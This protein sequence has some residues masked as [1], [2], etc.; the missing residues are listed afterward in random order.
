MENIVMTFNWNP[1]SRPPPSG[2]I[3]DNIRL[4]P[5]LNKI[6]PLILLFN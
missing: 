3:F 6:I 5:H 1:S 2:K 4:E